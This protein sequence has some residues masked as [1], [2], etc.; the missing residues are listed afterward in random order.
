MNFISNGSSRIDTSLFNKMNSSKIGK[1]ELRAAMRM[2]P[3]Y[4]HAAGHS[5][6]KRV[7]RWF[8][9]CLCSFPTVV[10]ADSRLVVV[11]Y[12]QN[13]DGS[14]GNL[15][16]DQAIRSTFATES[17]ERF[18]IYNEYL[19]LGKSRAAADEQLQRDYLRTKYRDRKVEVVIAGLSSGLDFALANRDLFSDAPIVYCAVDREE[20]RKRT[21]PSDAIGHPTEFDVAGTLDLAFKLLPQTR[22][23][24][25]VSGRSPMDAAWGKSI[26]E[27]VESHHHQIKLIDLTGLA[28]EELL[29]RSSNLPDNTI[30]YYV[31]VFQDA[32]GRTYVP[33]H[34][35]EILSQRANAPI[36]SHIDTYIGRG[37]V[38]GH[39]FKFEEEGRIAARI[40]LRLLEGESPARLAIESVDSNAYEF[41]GRQLSRWKIDENQL[42]EASLIRHRDEPFLSRYK[43]LIAWLVGFCVVQMGWI[44][45]LL[46]ERRRRRRADRRLQ[47]ALVELQT[48]QR[49][50]RQLSGN[51]ID[52]QE[53]ERRRI[54]RELH[55][56]FNQMLALLTV[57]L[58][59]LRRKLP[60]SSP[61]IVELA[62]EITHRV[63][64]LS[65]SIH[66]LSHELHPLKLEQLGLVT[67]VRSLCKEVSQ[68]HSIVV[69]FSADDIPR[70]IPAD[71]SLCLYRIVQEAL[72]NVV[73][74]S[75]ASAASVMMTRTPSEIVLQVSDQGIGFKPGTD[76]ELNGLGL[77]SMRER[78]RLVGGKMAIVSTAPHGL[79]LT[80][81]I[82]MAEAVADPTPVM[83]T[84]SSAPGV[85]SH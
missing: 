3:S 28:M 68:A 4:Q 78:L 55:D 30:V 84:R 56:D 45:G 74:H 77:I 15:L 20:I 9:L 60:T 64:D 41:D 36:F 50:L 24:A 37:I 42:P 26:S 39:V 57:Q 44:I 13:N 32:D 25:L 17:S 38:G 75:Q 70:E 35:L 52:V 71:I 33:A 6:W 21:L 34:V 23:V 47:H 5:A 46:M 85:A 1:K 82:P 27:L 29:Q 63:R 53:S 69:E 83:A 10:Q 80:V 43:T 22:N 76:E 11:L 59:L 48:N 14:P 12:P 73:K 40:A 81:Q 62:S 31:H 66:E 16:V 67:A 8:V 51:L 18:E 7:A 61:D 49:Q 58:E 79:T 54:A 2:R 72:H 19:D 65:T